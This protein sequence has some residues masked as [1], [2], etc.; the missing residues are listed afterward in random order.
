VQLEKE[1]YR[2]IV[3]SSFDVP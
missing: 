1:S 2:T 3:G